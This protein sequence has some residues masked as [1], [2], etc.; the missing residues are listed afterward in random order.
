MDAGIL[1]YNGYAFSDQSHI[2]VDSEF[3]Y[4]DA[5]RT[6]IYH[7]YRIT[8]D[9]IVVP[10][11]GDGDVGAT[12]LRIRQKLS[13]AGA[14]LKFSNKGFGQ[15]LEVNR[16]VVRDVKF[17]PKPRVLHW[18][19]IGHTNA[20]EIRWECET[21]IPVCEGTGY[22]PRF[23][24][25]ASFNYAID[26]AINAKGFTT[27]TITGSLTVAMTR[28]GRTI[29]D[30]ADR[31][32]GMVLTTKPDNFMREQQDWKISADKTRADFTIVDREVESRNAYPSGVVA[33]RG[34][35]SAGWS[36]RNRAYLPN[37][38]DVE[39]ELAHN[40]PTSRAWE[41]FLSIVSQ[42][43]RANRY[44]RK[45]IFLEGL[46]V[47]EDLFGTT[48]RFEVSYRILAEVGELFNV[49][50]M[51]HPLDFQWDYWARSIADVTG[52]RGISGMKHSPTEDRITDLCDN[53]SPSTGQPFSLARTPP[54][55]LPGKLCN[56][57]PHPRYSWLRFEATLTEQ[58]RWRTVYQTTLGGVDV[59]RKSFNPSDPDPALN[60]VELDS[61]VETIISEAP[62]SMRWRWSGVAERAGYPVAI[63]DKLTIGDVTLERAGDR[64]VIYR[65]LGTHF[66]IPLFGAAWDIEYQ[67][68]KR[69]KK[70]ESDNP[71]PAASAT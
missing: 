46:R 63:P 45:S 20:A 43:L 21:C 56:E 5:E 70:V 66:C 36:R 59:E 61:D 39:I 65:H 13:K 69:P 18:N 53:A 30:T 25:L 71:D 14:M 41:I 38:I 31:Y 27:R 51:F 26:Y 15:S 40:Q 32:R 60:K 10:D 64:N 24:G 37:S 47:N 50:G 16:G 19:P 17:G 54:L 7:R 67:V 8:V 1:E 55:S 49:S 3:V 2:E 35:H 29:P 23:R 57:R 52:S 33:I 22:G 28:V 9:A 62:P 58:T 12:M 4:D 44:E 68:T 34:N 11:A 42:R 48:L 6:V